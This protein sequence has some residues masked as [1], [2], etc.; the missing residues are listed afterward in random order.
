[1]RLISTQL[2]GI[3]L[4]ACKIEYLITSKEKK[5]RNISPC[6]RKKMDFKKIYN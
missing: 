4:H 3:W 1:M 6:Y 5:I 2:V